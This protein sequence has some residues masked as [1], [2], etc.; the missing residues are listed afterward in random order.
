MADV[1]RVHLVGALGQ[2]GWGGEVFFRMSLDSH[3][4][5]I[6]PYRKRGHG[7]ALLWSERFLLVVTEPDPA[8]NRRR[9]PDKPRVGEIVR[10]A[11]LA[12]QR[13]L[14]QAGLVS[15]A[16]QHHLAQHRGHDARG[17]R[18]DHVVHVRKIFFEHAP[19]VVHHLADQ[20]RRNAHAIVGKRGERRRLF[21]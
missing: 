15:G 7:A 1:G 9:E 17:P 6:D 19:F 10:G 11:G 2:V 14:Q 3:L 12:R 4:H 16:V 5:E 8:G 13:M 18:R 20:T 21:R